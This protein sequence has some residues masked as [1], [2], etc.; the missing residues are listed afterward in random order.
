M[1]LEMVELMLHSEIKTYFS[2]NLDKYRKA[3]YVFVFQKRQNVAK[4]AREIQSS[5]KKRE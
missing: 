2:K 1:Q 4:D 5:G 3:T